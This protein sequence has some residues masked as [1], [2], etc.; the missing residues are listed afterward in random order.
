M[1]LVL[2]LLIVQPYPDVSISVCICDAVKSNDCWEWK[3]RAVL[4]EKF[5]TA[6][7]L[8]SARTDKY[9]KVAFG[10]MGFALYNS[11]ILYLWA[12]F[13]LDLQR[14]HEY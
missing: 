3:H 12:V 4:Y 5:I 1:I 8:L 9:E 10:H 13:V 14:E 7:F 11:L 6:Q 2:F